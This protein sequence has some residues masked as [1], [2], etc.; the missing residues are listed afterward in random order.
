MASLFL[1]PGDRVVTSAGAYPTFNYHV[2]GYGGI[3]KFVPYRNDHEDI[4]V[5]LEE[6]EN[7]QAR[8]LYLSNPENPMGTWWIKENVG[9]MMN[10]VP[11]GTLLLLDEAYGEFAPPDTLPSLD[12]SN[13]RVLRLRTFF[14]AFG[15]AVMRVE[16]ATGNKE[17]I[18]EFNKVRNHF[19][20]GRVAQA[21]ARAALKDSSHL[22]NVISRVTDSL[23]RVRVIALKNGLKPL[24]TS[25]NF[26]AIDCGR[27]GI[28]AK[29]VM[30]ALIR[31]GIF[32]RMPGVAP[33]NRCIRI[34]AGLEDQI[35]SLT[36]FCQ[37]LW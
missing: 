27:D 9:S 33:L 14:K 12:V 17:L 7:H 31:H 20:V 13:T 34:T 15:L 26:I 37:G 24:P 11:N 25:A 36:K 22:V 29:V 1:E 8:L 4:E 32:V 3:L 28:Y 16:Y 19:G 2:N 6:S 10:Q 35:D 21:A 5:L 30:N 23:E 18:G